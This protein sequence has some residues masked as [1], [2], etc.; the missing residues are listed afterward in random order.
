M[1]NQK[2]RFIKKIF[3]NK[4]GPKY[5][6]SKI[7]KEISDPNM[8]FFKGKNV[9]FLFQQ[10]GG[11]LNKAI[12]G[13][14][15]GITKGEYDL[16]KKRKELVR[17]R[18]N[19]IKSSIEGDSSLFQ[20]V[21]AK[22]VKKEDY[23]EEAME[24]KKLI[25]EKKSIER[26]K[27]KEKLFEIHS[28]NLKII[29]DERKKKISKSPQSKS[30][31]S[32]DIFSSNI[33]EMERTHRQRISD[34]FYLKNRNYLENY[35]KI[36]KKIKKNKKEYITPGPNAYDIR[37]NYTDIG[38]GPTILGKRKELSS[39]K[40][41]PSFPDLKDEFELIAEK[42]NKSYVK[43]FRPR[44]EPLKKEMKTKPYP[45]ETIWKKWDMNKITME[46]QGRI[47]SFV[48]E[49]KRKKT[50][51]LIRMEEL[52]EQKEEINNLRREIA[53][54]KGYGDPYSLKSINYSQVE[55]GSPKYSIKGRYFISKKNDFDELSSM[56]PGNE[57]MTEL[58]QNAKLSSPLPNPDV[59][60]PKLPN[61]IFGKA[62]RFQ[63]TES[64]GLTDLFIDGN[65]S[66]KTHE[67][68]STKEPFGNSAKREF[69]VRGEKEIYPSPADYVIKSNFEIIAEKGKK[70]SDIREKIKIKESMKKSKYN[71]VDMDVNREE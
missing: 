65:F 30:F 68:F 12:E 39:T 8:D 55:Y 45:N 66:L 53:I 70:M 1:N 18:N 54:K 16:F 29:N 52:K 32:Q 56:F 36:L 9:A 17:R 28:N 44:F 46:K 64:Q 27:I 60:K 62:K 34:I 2:Y 6:L 63:A 58:I 48:D 21:E 67:N 15:F 47:R 5:N 7:K 38:R 22:K 71:M 37:N 59:T 50:K 11:V 13:Y 49:I 35:E 69:K 3:Y 33:K 43:E 10:K 26:N 24:R 31:S 25:L 61:I 20:K 41:D 23:F 40:A 57:K 51:Q 42:A 19:N 14:S 4:S